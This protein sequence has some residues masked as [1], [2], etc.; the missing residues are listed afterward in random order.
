MRLRSIATTFM[1]VA[2]ALAAVACGGGQTGTGS[3]SGASMLRAGVFVFVAVDS[4]LDSAQW[5]QVDELLR[6]FPGRQQWLSMLRAELEKENVN[7]E[8]DVQPALGPE[9]DFVVVNTPGADE[10]PVAVLLTKPDD[11]AKTEAL[12]RKLNEG[13][14]SE[15]EAVSR[16]VD[17]WVFLSDKQTSI[18]AAIKGDREALAD[19]GLFNGAMDEAPEEAIAKVFVNGRSLSRLIKENL[20][21][22]EITT[23]LGLDRID[24]FMFWL[25]A[26]D[27]GVRLAGAVKG[28]GAKNLGLGAE[29]YASKL[30]QDA[31]AGALLFVSFRGGQLADQVRK[32]KDNPLYLMGLK[33][34]EQELGVT[35][36]ELVSLIKGELAFYIRPGAPLP[37]FTLLLESENEQ[38]DLQTVQQLARKLASQGGGTVTEEDQGG[39]KV[40]RIQLE[41]LAVLIAAFD[42][43]VALTT[44]RKGIDDLRGEGDRLTEDSDYKDA[45]S[46][47][48]VPDKTGGLVYINLE[49]GLPFVSDFAATAGADLPAEVRENLRPLKSV[50]AFGTTT[51]DTTT[52]ALFL[53][54]R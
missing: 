32:L 24:S 29:P 23:T 30:V 16:T 53:E 54:I 33:D 20:P 4:D 37:E 12:V 22:D 50:V 46:A 43:K 14:E 17:G 27:N 1:A 6:K 25:A 21:D 38:A 51:G 28:K 39:V 10:E 52:S 40:T 15:E 41:G 9:V 2:L 26:E 36:E 8:R 42:G 31:P 34:F 49:Q 13:G 18:D 7:W 44:A 5:Q 45:L 47:A 11:P 35:L 48:D 19:D 3:E